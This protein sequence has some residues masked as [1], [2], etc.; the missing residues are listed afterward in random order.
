MELLLPYTGKDELLLKK[1]TQKTN[2]MW[3]KKKKQTHSRREKE[4]IQRI[5]F[6]LTPGSYRYLVS[7]V[8]LFGFYFFVAVDSYLFFFFFFFNRGGR[9]GTKAKFII[10]IFFFIRISKTSR[11]KAEEKKNIDKLPAGRPPRDGTAPVV[12]RFSICELSEGGAG[13][14]DGLRAHSARSRS[15]GHADVEIVALFSLIKNWF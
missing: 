1:H 10:F 5:Y 14:W 11:L 3:E 13:R 9:G 15:A 7:F 8:G 6:L 4:T 12:G 2:K